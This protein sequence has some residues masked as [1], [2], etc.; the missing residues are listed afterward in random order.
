[1]ILA[2]L[3]DKRSVYKSKLFSCILATN[4]WN[5]KLEIPFTVTPK[6]EIHRYKFKKIYAGSLCKNLQ[7]TDERSQ[8]RPK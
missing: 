3:Q 8:R 4:N 6:D 2:R 5:L 1:M 7:N